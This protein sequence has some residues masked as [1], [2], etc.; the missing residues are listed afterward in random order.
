M[1][2]LSTF[3]SLFLRLHVYMHTYIFLLFLKRF[4]VTHPEFIG[5][6]QNIDFVSTYVV[7]ILFS[8]V[9][10]NQID[11]FQVPYSFHK[12]RIIG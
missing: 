11:S 4:L 10:W 5:F 6:S 8:H 7:Y 9:L 12:I 1:Y 2:R 3:Y